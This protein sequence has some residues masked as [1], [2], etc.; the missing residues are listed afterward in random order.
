MATIAAVHDLSGVGRCSLAAAI[1]VLTAMGH[2]CCPL[3]TASL[4]AQTGFEHYS[5]TDLTHQ[6][7]EY[8]GRWDEMGLELDLFYSGFL[9]SPEQPEILA[10]FLSQPHRRDMWVMVD[11]VMG[12]HGRMYPCFDREY[13]R[14]L[15]RLLPHAHLITPNLTELCLLADRPTHALD[16]YTPKDCLDIAREI[17]GGRLSQVVVTGIVQGDRVTNLAIDLERDFVAEIPSPYT[18][19]SYSGTGD[20]FACVVCG[21]LAQ[22]LDLRESVERAADFVRRA[23][24]L[25][26]GADPRYGVHYEKCIHLL[27]QSYRGPTQYSDG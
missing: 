8:L 5:S 12:D 6:M 18:H 3:P 24:A 10:D 2:H 13:L 22:G 27:T 23:V 25:S 17:C 7:R 20:L 9:G 26:E 11:P 4:S 21:S 14:A 16:Q 15:R 19:T 1:G